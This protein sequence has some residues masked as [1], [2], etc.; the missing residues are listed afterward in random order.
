MGKYL[1]RKD[2]PKKNIPL[3]AAAVLLCLTLLSTHLV[4]GLFAR[5][6]ASGQG[7]DQAR[8][9]KFSIQGSGMLSHALEMTL[10]PG[11]T[12]TAPLI[13][14]NNSEVAVEYTMEVTNVTN[15]LPLSFRIEKQ[16][17]SPELDTNG[18]TFTA[19]QLP[20]SHYDQYAL[21]IEWPKP[22]DD[23]AKAADLSRI[24]MVDYI[25]VTVTAAQLD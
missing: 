16:K 21:T 20:G 23:D 1:H 9:A 6:T 4:S 19:Q 8:V 22:A 25:T 10:R 5:Y 2:R 11:D 14:V 24:G 15:N 3:R 17:D 13:I 7:G 12:K 18:A